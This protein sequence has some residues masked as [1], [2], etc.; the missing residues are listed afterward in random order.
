MDEKKKLRILITT[1]WYPTSKS[2]SG[3][4]VK[5][6]GEALC[7]AGHDVTVL[8]VRYSTLMKWLRS[9]FGESGPVNDK[10]EVLR[11]VE[12]HVV[13][14]LPGRF[15]R[16]PQA[17][18][19]RTITRKILRSVKRL[20]GRSGLPDIIHHHSLSDNSYLAS[21][22]A[23]T[24][25]IPYVFTEHSNYFTYG[26][27]NRFN[28][29]E[30]FEDHKKFLEGACS[31][32]AVSEVR[33][34]AY[35]EIFGTPFSALPNMVIRDF[36]SPLS[37]EPK[38][39]QFTFVCVALLDKRKRQDVLLK[40]F[41]QAFNDQPVR[42]LLV[43]HGNMETEYRQLSATLG[44]DGQVVFMGK[45]SREEI[46]RIFDRSHV[47]VLSSDQETFGI[48]LAEAM[49]RGIPAISTVSGG[50]EEVITPGSGLL[51]PKGDIDALA[52]A[53]KKIKETYSSYDPAD[54]RTRAIARYSEKT[55]I[56]KLEAVYTGCLVAG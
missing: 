35:A 43:G 33:A 49:F 46:I 50:P 39:E 10:S 53:M 44:L 30:T 6:Q 19:K 22:I 17:Y 29:F 1:S 52:A 7:R 16:D 23:T 38:E 24:F 31:R 47:A 12:Y 55:I 4:F 36:E 9:I 41:R 20:F 14:P 28:R 2:T 11:V 56:A 18:F 51:C 8:L 15:F 54:I 40:A 5:E 25:S 27:L 34:K 26:E 3:V 42:L 45:R 21:A 13:F 48:V 32:I 37:T